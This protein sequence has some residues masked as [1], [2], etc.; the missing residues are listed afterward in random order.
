MRVGAWS[1]TILHRITNTPARLRVLGSL[2]FRIA[3]ERQLYRLQ[4]FQIAGGAARS[5]AQ[6]TLS[7]PHNFRFD[8]WVD[9]L[10]AE[11]RRHARRHGKDEAIFPLFRFPEK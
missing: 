1:Q 4:R 11:L 2:E 6:L 5:K 9:E 10:D 3:I 7:R 8:F